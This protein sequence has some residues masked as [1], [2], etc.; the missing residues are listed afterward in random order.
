M[1]YNSKVNKKFNIEKGWLILFLLAV[2]SVTLNGFA[3]GILNYLF[4]IS[5]VL[6]ILLAKKHKEV[7]VYF[8]LFIFIGYSKVSINLPGV[9]IIE[10]ATL[11]NVFCILIV[12]KYIIS[13]RFIIRKNICDR[14]VLILTCY[15][16]TNTLFLFKLSQ[17][18]A[19]F[20]KIL[21]V[22]LLLNTL[23][24][25]KEDTNTIMACFAITLV[26]EIVYGVLFGMQYVE[27]G[28]R[29]LQFTGVYDPNNCAIHF[30]IFYALYLMYVK[31]NANKQIN[32]VV[33]VVVTVVI[34]STL[35]FS[36]I[37]MIFCL[38]VLNLL[39]Q[40]R[41]FKSLFWIVTF[42]VI[43]LIG[44]INFQDII[45]WMA[46]SDVSVLQGLGSRFA[47]MKA[48]YL[49]GNTAGLTSGRS[50][51]WKQYLNWFQEEHIFY[52]IIGNTGYLGYLQTISNA[53]HNF[54]IDSLINYGYLGCFII[55]VF[56]IDNIRRLFARMDYF[57][58]CVIVIFWGLMFSRTVSIE[59]FLLISL[60]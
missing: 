41:S 17:G 13:E 28:W 48:E 35:S 59:T 49:A 38:H 57:K 4:L 24:R 31:D 15:V 22:L 36:G 5:S 7:N 32:R 58:A 26:G 10:N 11:Y 34:I 54:Y 47:S 44:I 21:V 60:L 30:G 25:S 2:S 42:F 45:L 12:L 3:N 53:S 20:F 29:T 16:V 43:L 52:Q 23:K 46:R 18:L 37:V 27:W 9:G 14:I 55:I 6:S 19:V 56:M 33:S 40:K 8:I 1:E 39:S 51:L 50:V